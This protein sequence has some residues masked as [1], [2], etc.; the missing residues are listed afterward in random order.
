MS[1]EMRSHRVAFY[2]EHGRWPKPCGC[3]SCDNRP[4]CNPAHIFEGTIQENT[5]D[6]MRKGRLGER[7]GEANGFHR[8]TDELAMEIWLLK[9]NL[10][11]RKIAKQMCISRHVVRQIHFSKSWTH[12]THRTPAEPNPL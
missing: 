5:A 12:I 10:S 4:C 3:H 2:L 11:P 9:G 8:L 7:R 6:M 1:K